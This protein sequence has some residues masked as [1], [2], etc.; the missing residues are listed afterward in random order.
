[1]GP[2]SA[3]WSLPSTSN[4]VAAASS[5]TVSVSS[6]AAGSSSTQFTLTETV[7]VEPPFSV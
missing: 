4:V 7:A 1:M 2:P 6:T 3:F 5:V